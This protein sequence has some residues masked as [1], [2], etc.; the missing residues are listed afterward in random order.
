MKKRLTALLCVVLCL[1]AIFSLTGCKYKTERSNLWKYKYED[2]DAP[3]L[4]DAGVGRENANEDGW[5]ITM[6]ENFDG[7]ELPDNWKTSMNINRNREMYWCRN[8]AK[9][10]DGYLKLG[11]ETAEQHNKTCPNVARH[12]KL[13]KPATTL[14][15]TAFYKGG[16]GYDYYFTQAFGYYEIKCK[17]PESD[18]MWMSFWLQNPHEGRTGDKGKDGSEIDI[19][20]SAFFNDKTKTASCIHYDGYGDSTHLLEGIHDVGVNTYDGFHTYA[21]KWTPTEYV[22]YYD[23]EPIWATD[24]D[25]GVCQTP[26]YL[27]I[28]GHI[29]ENRKAAYKQMMGELTG[30]ELLVDYVKVYQNKSYEE[31]IKQWSDFD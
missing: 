18:G 25:G 11:A 4:K 13:D 26:C 6:D 14:V 21:L 15:G 2:T 10:E 27:N 29:A 3:D 7:N 8:M 12:G 22:F 23:G 1:A 5:Y 24:G 30:G 31:H 20:E 19:F 9:V 16:T 28:S 17:L